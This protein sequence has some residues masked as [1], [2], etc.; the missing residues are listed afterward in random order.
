[1]ST[2]HSEVH[3]KAQVRRLGSDHPAFE[4]ERDSFGVFTK[5][6]ELSDDCVS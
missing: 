3:C 5:V 4:T 2:Y 6:R 1:M